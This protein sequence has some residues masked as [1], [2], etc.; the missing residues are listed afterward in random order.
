MIYVLV[1]DKE[2]K[3]TSQNE[4]P[5]HSFVS[6]YT[7]VQEAY[8]RRIHVTATSTTGIATTIHGD[9]YPGGV[10]GA[11]I[12]AAMGVTEYG[13][14]VG[15]GS[16]AVTINDTKLGSVLAHG[17]GSN[18]LYHTPVFFEPLVVT[19]TEVYLMCRRHY[20]NNSVAVI[21]ITESGLI[22]GGD[23]T[24]AGRILM[25]RDVFPSSI[26]IPIAGYAEVRYKIGIT[27]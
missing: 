24:T 18:Q 13:I 26:A 11:R 3:L 12:D 15:T 10:V 25:V 16:V 19:P 14:V 1:W 5:M 27:T 9:G 21:T 17:T 2:G 23:G 20:F 8:A 6:N 7:R 4:F 22:C